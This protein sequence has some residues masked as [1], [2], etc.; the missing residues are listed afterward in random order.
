M[1][2]PWKIVLAVLCVP[3]VVAAAVQANRSG[4]IS[5]ARAGLTLLVPAAP[6][7]GWDTVAR[8]MQN[9]MRQNGIVT[10][11][12]V[13]NVP[14]AGGTIGLG[15]LVDQEGAGDVLMVMGT[16][17]VG[18]IEVNDSEYSLDQTTPVAHLADDYLALVVPADSP[19]Q[20]ID[21]FVQ[22]FGTDP[23]S[24]AI[25][26]GSLGGTDHLTAGLLAQ[27]IGADPGAINYI[28]FAGGGEAINALLSGSVDAGVSGYN[29]FADQIET[30]NLRLLALSA[31]APQE[32]I[33]AP[34]FIQA[35]YDV[36]L[37]NFRGVVAPTGLDDAEVQELTD[38]VEETVATPEWADALRRNKWTENLQTGDAYGDFLATETDRIRTIVEE[39]GL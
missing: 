7:G 1:S 18:G 12:R 37:P 14:G 13:V 27:E 15:Q 30:G 28:P 3:L 22:T 23:G 16:V 33:D 36:Y 35:G 26:G 11:P 24:I 9:A 8:E 19:Y 25:G 2:R 20:D 34:T 21:A 17:M 10:N 39:L 32:G 38:I 4:D 5:G 6:G 29:E 31:P